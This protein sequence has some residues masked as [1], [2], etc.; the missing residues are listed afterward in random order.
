[1]KPR[2]RLVILGREGSGKT[3]YLTQLYRQLSHAT[4][5]L[6][7]IAL[8]GPA[9][10][11]CVESAD[12]L[13][14]G[15]WPEPTLGA[16]FLE[17][18]ITFQGRHAQL[19]ALDY[20]G[21]VFHRTFVDHEESAE[22]AEMLDHLDRAA[23]VIALIDPGAARS[24]AQRDLVDDDFG[25]A[26]ALQR[27]RSSPG[28]D[29]VPVAIVLTKCDLHMDLLKSHGGMKPFFEKTYGNLLRRVGA[30]RLFGCAA[31]VARADESGRLVPDPAREPVRVTEPM[32]ACMNALL[33][34]APTA[35]PPKPPPPPVETAAPAPAAPVAPAPGRPPTERTLLWPVVWTAA[36]LFF[37]VIALG[38]WMIIT[39]LP[40][41]SPPP[42]PPLATGVAP[43]T[44]A[45]LE[46]QELYD[47]IQ[48]TVCRV[49]LRQ[50]VRLD[51]WK[52]A[53]L[54]VGMG[55][56]CVIR[57][58]GLIVTNA[59]VV[60]TSEIPDVPDMK[61][62]G[63]DV[64]VVF[65]YGGRTYELEADEVQT[66]RRADL[67]WLKVDHRFTHA[68]SIAPTPVPGQPAKAFGY[69]W[70]ADGEAA[71]N[72][73]ED[74][75]REY[76]DLIRRLGT[77]REPTIEEWLGGP[78]NLV[79]TVTAGIISAIRDTEEGLYIQTDTFVHNGNSGGPL[80]DGTGRILGLVT[81]GSNE[82]ESTNFCIGGYT[83]WE[84]LKNERGIDWPP[85]W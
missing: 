43:R 66:S 33:A 8:N 22:T 77:D 25:M 12:E 34:P 20:P 6:H 67:A 4:D 80:V 13:A 42:P 24:G 78:G 30:Y 41:A 9:H 40:G 29:R 21:Q 69:P 62:V 60:D 55:T 17:L 58:D 18:E 68:L 3:V 38:T 26:A 16:W 2:D 57:R 65:H 44:A 75:M 73:I 81:F 49:V 23:A 64:V 14:A 83:L 84:E 61:V 28:G 76:N 71:I 63:S 46:A 37:I 11:A 35:A 52:V 59:H 1:M 70:V 36:A 79:P 74:N 51:R 27:V 82:V 32:A 50:H 56:G 53:K 48:R 5:E 31:A 39:N 45:A 54:P 19:Y 85:G 15:R 47:L 72:Q 10:Q 7:M